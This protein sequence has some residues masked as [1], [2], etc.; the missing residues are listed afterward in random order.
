MIITIGNNRYELEYNYNYANNIPILEN[1]LYSGSIYSVLRDSTNNIIGLLN[2]EN[3]QVVR[4]VYEGAVLENVFEVT[5]YGDVINHNE[6]FIGNLNGVC[7]QDAYYDYESGLYYKYR[8]Y[9][10]SAEGIYITGLN[11]ENL[12]TETNPFINDKLRSWEDSELYAEEWKLELMSD[13]SHGRALDYSASWYDSLSTVEILSR[14]IYAE[15]SGSDMNERKGVAYVIMN[16][17]ETGDTNSFGEGLRGVATKAKQFASITGGQNDTTTSRNPLKSGAATQIDYINWEHATFLACLLCTTL[18]QYEW[19]VI[20]SRPSGIT[21]QL[22]FV[23]YNYGINWGKFRDSSSGIQYYSNGKW[24]NV[25][26]VAICGYGV[27]NSVADI[28]STN[29]GSTNRNIFFNI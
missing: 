10:N 17:I 29:T 24:L 18:D 8:R 9:Y 14:L 23:S 16:R 20:S 27:F 28:K 11:K 6:D 25:N 21:N 15:N 3:V 5:E 22:Y 13:S 19:S 7:W 4:Y 12:Y 2:E 26:K 1:I